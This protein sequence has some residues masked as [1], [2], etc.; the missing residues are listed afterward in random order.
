VAL[1]V[2]TWHRN[3]NSK[4]RNS[5][6]TEWDVRRFGFQP[7]TP[8]FHQRQ[9][10]QTKKGSPRFCASLYIHSIEDRNQAS[11]EIQTTDRLTNQP[12]T[13]IKPH[14][15]GVGLDRDEDLPCWSACPATEQRGQQSPLDHSAAKNSNGQANSSAWKLNLSDATYSQKEFRYATS[16]RWN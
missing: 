14:R 16:Y 2:S 8:S 12:H 5:L 9:K 13:R 6:S 1:T 3:D 11:H 4:G 7:K 15:Q 10:R